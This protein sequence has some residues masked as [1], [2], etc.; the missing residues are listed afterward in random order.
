MSDNDK[1][2]T[3]L[4]IGQGHPAQCWGWWDAKAKECATCVVGDK[5]ADA[6]RRL[7]N[8]GTPVPLAS[9][10]PSPVAPA[11]KA[12]ASPVASTPKTI[13]KPKSIVVP[14]D[15]PA[16]AVEPSVQSAPTAESVAAPVKAQEEKPAEVA[17]AP[18]PE[19]KSEQPSVEKTTG[20]R[21][22]DI[23]F[24]RVGGAFSQS[25]NGLA[26]VFTFVNA[27]GKN[28]F[29]VGISEKAKKVK[30]QTPSNAFKV[31]DFSAT[32]DEVNAALDALL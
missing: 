30:L 5:C 9:S 25:N 14:K 23:V 20:N 11:A 13:V 18:K 29:L 3:K 6:T 21:F 19:V 26:V 2:E 22:A 16:T 27:D 7:S 8:K 32:D 10:V 4:A 15:E 24:G 12:A 28:T 1:I 17:E 31:L